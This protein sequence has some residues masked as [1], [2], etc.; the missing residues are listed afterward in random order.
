M[1]HVVTLDEN[2]EAVQYLSSKDK[3]LCKVIK[4]LGPI[5]YAP[6]EDAFA[7]LVNQILSQLL[8]AKVSKKMSERLV[9]LCGGQITPENVL[10]LSPSDIRSTGASIQKAQYILGLASSFVNGEIDTAHLNELPDKEI[11][12]ELT[13]IKGIGSWT[14]KMYLIFVLNRDDV[15][16]FEDYAFLQGYGW[17]YKTDDFS[18][19]SVEKKTMKWRP[20]RSIAARYLYRALDGGLTKQEFHL[21]KEIE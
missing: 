18:R 15:L 10:K 12:K 19:K 17:L 20:Y 13:K 8:A 21:H 16:P 11:I 14:A 1:S 7:F 5:T 6:Y 4:M 3:R 2:N 9:A